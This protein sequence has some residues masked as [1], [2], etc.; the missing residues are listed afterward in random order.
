[1]LTLFHGMV[2]YRNHGKDSMEK[3]PEK[4]IQ[5]K[6][7]ANKNRNKINPRK[8]NHRKKKQNTLTKANNILYYS[9]SYKSITNNSVKLSGIFSES[10]K[11]YY[12]NEPQ[13]LEIMRTYQ[14]A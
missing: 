8:K 11:I 14:V 1:M 3:N 2:L 10:K 12:H 5:E 13:I 6:T 7:Y 4:E 9:W